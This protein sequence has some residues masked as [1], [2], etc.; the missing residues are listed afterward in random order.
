M[1]RSILS[2]SGR[3]V[4]ARFA[5]LR[6]LVAFDY[7]GTLAPIA[8]TPEPAGMRETTR[9]LLARVAELYPCAIVS[10]RAYA[11][12]ASRLA[13]TPVRFL[14]GNHGIEP[15][16]I[17]R[18]GAARVRQWIAELQPQFAGHVGIV[19]EDKT[20]SIAVHYR[21]A[22]DR[23]RAKRLV[24]AAVA[25]LPGARAIAGRSAI[26]V[27]PEGSANKG[28]ALRQACR[29][30]RCGYAI[31]VGDDGTDEDAFGALA[32]KRLLSI[33]VGRRKGSRARYVLPRQ[34]DIDRLLRLLVTLRATMPAHRRAKRLP[35]RTAHRRQ[36]HRG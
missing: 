30:A 19:L 28:A 2:A 1:T 22:P 15:L 14:F 18:S 29:L 13:A 24:T 20:H 10:G 11:D 4:A 34:R 5:R 35:R 6:V 3:R 7:D 27:I 8:M 21:A 17:D 31:Y 16:A 12:L 25:Q 26:N 36:P 32:A 9:E 33:R 23:R